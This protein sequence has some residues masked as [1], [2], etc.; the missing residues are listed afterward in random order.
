MTVLNNVRDY[1]KE[2]G[3]DF[4]VISHQETFTTMEEARASGVSPDHVAKTLVIKMRDG[5]ALA[6]LP[7]H[8]RLDMHKLRDAVH[9][10]H[11]RLA[12]EDEMG[13]EFTD[14][15]LGAVPPLGDLF[16][17]PVLMDEQL[18]DMDE[19]IFAGGTHRD[20]VKM[21]GDDFIR[22]THPRIMDL[23]REPGEGMAY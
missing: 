23:A 11:A 16:Q 2:Q 13:S 20:S 9:D 15:E 12:T 1:L 8:E 22:M 7:A 5:E 21:A 4:E 17:L 18:K 19:V 10:N 6:V 14:I 3:V